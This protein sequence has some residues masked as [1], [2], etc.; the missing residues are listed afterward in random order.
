MNDTSIEIIV[1]LFEIVSNYQS[2]LDTFDSSHT[3]SQ[4]LLLKY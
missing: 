4:F 2:Y 3:I 1:G